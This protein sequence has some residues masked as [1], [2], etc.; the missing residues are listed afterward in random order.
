MVNLSFYDAGQ[1]VPTVRINR[2]KKIEAE[3][4]ELTK[5]IT[6]SYSMGVRNISKKQP[7]TTEEKTKAFEKADAF[8]KAPKFPNFLIVMNKS[9]VGNRSLLVSFYFYFNFSFI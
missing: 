7:S 1:H 9:S 6:C 4:V 5:Y 2:F 3:D 8:E